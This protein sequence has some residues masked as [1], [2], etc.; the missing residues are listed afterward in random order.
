MSRPRLLLLAAL[1][2]LLFVAPATPQLL[3]RNR[4]AAG[5][6]PEPVAETKL[7]MEGLLQA[8]VRGL[9]KNLQQPPTDQETWAF[10]RGQSLLIA[11][12][13]NLLMLRPPRIEGQDAWLN[14]AAELREKATTLARSAASRDADGC[15]RGLLNL[16][17]TCNRCHQ[18]F[19]VN[20]QVTPFAQGR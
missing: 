1:T 7:L 5:P 18:T 2:P 16:A 19:R 12:T 14:A 6:K 13:G 11:E 17:N 9:E 20:A 10:V 15:R 4:P 3:P 8:N